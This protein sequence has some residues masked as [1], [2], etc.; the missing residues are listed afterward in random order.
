[1]PATESDNLLQL[2]PKQQTAIEHLL[3]GKSDR[4]T[5]DA[6]GVH[7][8]TVTNWRLHHPAFQAELNSRRTE[9]RHVATERLLNLVAK[10]VE[11][12]EAELSG[13]RN[14]V[15]KAHYIITSVGLAE[16]PNG[17]A[18]TDAEVLLD[19]KIAAEAA[20]IRRRRQENMSQTEQLLADLQ[21]PTEE[22]KKADRA[23]AEKCVL[24]ELTELFADI[25]SSSGD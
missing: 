15:A 4:E 13:D 19:Q 20:S 16:L 17:F 25:E 10:A 12:L 3:T 11:E 9:L 7:R 24:A 2:T 21:G 22:E 23:E 18:A 8:T 14:R 1:M 6:V 5:A